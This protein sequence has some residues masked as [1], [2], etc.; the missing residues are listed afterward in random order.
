MTSY[1]RNILYRNNGNGTFADVTDKAGVAAT[2]WSTCAVW[3]D[4]DNDAKPDLFVSSFIVY[5]K[6]TSCGDN[7]LKR[8]YTAS[9]ARSSRSRAI[10]FT[11][12]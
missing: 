1:G 8:N 7:R 3:F 5:N 6:S 12:T 2:G 11:I 9:C 10:C 4:Y